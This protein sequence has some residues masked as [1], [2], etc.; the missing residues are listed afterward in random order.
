M[1]SLSNLIKALICTIPILG[2]CAQPE[3]NPTEDYLKEAKAAIA[4][5]NAIYFTS[6]ANNDSALFIDRYAE[7]ACLMPAGAPKTCGREALA[8]F[9]RETYNKG[10]R[11][12]EFVTVAVYGDG[13]EFVTEEVIGRI[14][15]EKKELMSEGKILV[16]WKKTAKGWKMFRD[17]FSGDAPSGK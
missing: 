6:F 12:G 7:D 16:L 17:S 5:S 10:Y 9:F 3:N 14:F 2:S 11:G 13:R 4:A 8:R 15:N 1:K